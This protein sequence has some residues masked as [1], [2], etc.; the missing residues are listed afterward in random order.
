MSDF[1]LY[2]DSNTSVTLRP[3]YDFSSGVRKIES[4]F[5]S[6]SGPEYAFK[7]ADYTK[8]TFTATHIT[9]ADATQINSW[10]LSNTELNFQQGAETPVSVRL[11]GNKS[12]IAKRSKPNTFLHK[13]TINLEGF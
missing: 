8:I 6:K 2:Q 3:E 5:R 1:F 13:G 11:V 9:S 7:W 4:R 10:W 12:P